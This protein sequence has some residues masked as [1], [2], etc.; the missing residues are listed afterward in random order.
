MLTFNKCSALTIAL[1]TLFFAQSAAAHFGMV[2]P[3]DSMVMQN[4]ARTIQVTYSF[5]HPMEMVGM[6]LVRQKRPK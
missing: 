5:S 2:I 6:K 4:D 3:S 1:F